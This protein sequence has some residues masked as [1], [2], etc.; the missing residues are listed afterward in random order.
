M[1]AFTGPLLPPML[2]SLVSVFY[3]D[4][5]LA[6]RGEFLHDRNQHP[7][8]LQPHSTFLLFLSQHCH[9]QFFPSS[10]C[11]FLPAPQHCFLM[12]T[13]SLMQ[14]NKLKLYSLQPACFSFSSLTPCFHGCF[15]SFLSW[16]TWLLWECKK[17]KCSTQRKWN[18]LLKM[19]LLAGSYHVHGQQLS[20]LVCWPGFFLRVLI[21]ERCCLEHCVPGEGIFWSCCWVSGAIYNVTHCVNN[22]LSDLVPKRFTQSPSSVSEHLLRGSKSPLFPHRS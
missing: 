11:I 1:R 22:C 8:I 6:P 2:F 5:S 3:R 7:I 21:F 13:Y 16:P 12:F 14:S 4:M 19:V 18:D 10:L 9:S 17:E 15:F 20:G